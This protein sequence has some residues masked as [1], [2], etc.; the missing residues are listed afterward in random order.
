MDNIVEDINISCEIAEHILSEREYLDNRDSRDTPP[1]ALYNCA[2]DPEEHAVS[3]V[4][5]LMH[6]CRRNGQSFADDVLW[7]A[8]QRYIADLDL[9][10]SDEEG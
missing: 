2:E 9:L 5:A 7:L 4:L 1:R 10:Q 6:H 8:E 3:I